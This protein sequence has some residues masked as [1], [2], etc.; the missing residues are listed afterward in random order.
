MPGI[1]PIPSIKP[2]DVDRFWSSA[3]KQGPEECWLWTKLTYRN[4]Y[5]RFCVCMGNYVATRIAYRL[6]NGVDPGQMFVC[7]TCDNP[8]CVNPAHLFLGTHLDNMRDCHSKKRNDCGRGERHGTKTHPERFR[9]EANG[10]VLTEAQVRAIRQEYVNSKKSTL[11]LGTEYNVSA[12]TIGHVLRA[13]TWAHVAADDG[14]GEIRD[15][16]R[17]GKAGSLNNS[18]RINEDDVREIRRLY[19]E[20]GFTYAALAQQFGISDVAARFVIIGRTWKHVP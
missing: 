6:A 5:P 3:Q 20:G 4:G 2:K 9:G 13:E 16:S 1:K 15:L 7:H 10:S 19:Q 8:I 11:Q 14:L 18:A 17:R 12:E